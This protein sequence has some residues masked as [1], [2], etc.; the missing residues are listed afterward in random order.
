MLNLLTQ[1]LL[2]QD[3]LSQH[4]N[5]PIPV[6]TILKFLSDYLTLDVILVILILINQLIYHNHHN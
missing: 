2:V 1:D 3:E 6:K 5:I 4:D